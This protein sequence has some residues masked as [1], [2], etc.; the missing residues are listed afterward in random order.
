MV[1]ATAPL[2]LAIIIALGCAIFL[3]RVDETVNALTALTSKQQ[4]AFEQRLRGLE[5]RLGQLRSEVEIA[6]QRSDGGRSAR[7][8]QSVI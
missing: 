5:F 7:G 4:S 6:K 8:G 2:V 1:T 3:R